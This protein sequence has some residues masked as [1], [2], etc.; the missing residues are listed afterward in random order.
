MR[1]N[2]TGSNLIWLTITSRFTVG[3]REITIVKAKKT[4][5][6]PRLRV[7]IHTRKM[8]KSTICG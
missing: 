6:P 4:D 1:I 8:T 3:K 5:Y 2:G 7:A